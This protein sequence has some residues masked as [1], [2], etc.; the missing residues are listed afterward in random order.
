MSKKGEKKRSPNFELFILILSSPIG[1]GESH[2]HTFPV[3]LAT[4]ESHFPF[5]FYASVLD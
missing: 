2:S 3:L 1:G 4:V 5:L